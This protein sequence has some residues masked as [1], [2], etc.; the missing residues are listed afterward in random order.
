MILDNQGG[1]MINDQKIPLSND[2]VQ[3]Q[4]PEVK[5]LIPKKFPNFTG[6]HLCLSLSL[7]FA[8]LGLQLY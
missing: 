4:A 7:L 1:L 8:D 6:K 3:K 5:E 2:L